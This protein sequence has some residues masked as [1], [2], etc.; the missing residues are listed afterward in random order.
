MNTEFFIARRLSFDKRNSRSVKVMT[1]IAVFSIMLSATVMIVA[2]STLSGFKTGLKEKISGFNA[3]LRI[4]NLDSNHSFDTAPILNN[5]PFYDSIANMPDVKHLRQYAYKGGIIKTATEIQGVVLKG[6]DRNFGN[7]FFQQYL[8]DGSLLELSDTALSSKA[9]ISTS[10]SKLLNLKTGDHF[11]VYFVQEPVRIRRFTVSGLYDTNLAEMDKMFVI[12]DIAHIRR[13]NGWNGNQISGMEIVL[14][15]LTDIDR[16]RTRVSDWIFGQIDEETMLDV[17]TIHDDFP[18]IFN[19]LDIIDMNVL[20]VLIIMMVVAGFNMISSLLIMLLE[21]IPMI[22]ILKTMGM[23][24]GNI[25]KIFI[26]KS[27]LIVLRGLAYGNML[28]LMLC[29]GQQLFEFVKLNPETYFFTVAPVSINLQSII[30]LNI[31]SFAFI[32]ATQTI[33]AIIVA[34]ISPDKTVKAT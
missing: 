6:I 29:F 26:Y 23:S 10:L 16:A 14:N 3:H 32:V 17:N 13:L 24:S 15:S 5:Y 19:W 25:R 7:E 2:I 12:C 34:K 4:T 18:H 20:I 30:L 8:V 11:D 1:R 9:L 33:P 22:G 31:C 27:S 21:K 28:G